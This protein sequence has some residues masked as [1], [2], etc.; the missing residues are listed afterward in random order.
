MENTVQLL[1]SITRGQ[2]KVLKVLGHRLVAP[3]GLVIL[4]VD[5]L[6]SFHSIFHYNMIN[7]LYYTYF[8]LLL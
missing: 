3:Q 7:I 4:L 2:N 5:Y 1:A 6:L 8:V